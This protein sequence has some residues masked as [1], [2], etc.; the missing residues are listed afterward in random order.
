MAYFVRS[1]QCAENQVD[2]RETQPPSWFLSYALDFPLPRASEGDLPAMDGRSAFSP[3]MDSPFRQNGWTFP[4]SASNPA[5]VG[6]ARNIFVAPRPIAAGRIT[7][8]VWMTT[9]TAVAVANG[10]N[11]SGESD[12]CGSKLWRH[13]DLPRFGPRRVKIDSLP[14][15]YWLW[16]SLQRRDLKHW[17]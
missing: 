12:I 15:L 17:A 9:T 3:T 1:L 8:I 13:K 14:L 10:E 4:P 16:W 7:P 11:G 6:V 5:T 2:A